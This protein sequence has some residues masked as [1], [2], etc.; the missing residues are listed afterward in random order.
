MYTLDTTAPN[1]HHSTASTIRSAAG[2]SRTRANRRV[3]DRVCQASGSRGNNRPSVRSCDVRR[4]RYMGAAK[5][6][7][8]HLMTGAVINVLRMLNWLAEVPKAKT[9]PSPF[10]R[11]YRPPVCAYERGNSPPISKRGTRRGSNQLLIR[12][13]TLFTMQCARVLGR[14]LSRQ[15]SRVERSSDAWFV[16]ISLMTNTSKRRQLMGTSAFK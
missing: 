3:Q 10:V 9:R 12:T 8:Q 14:H 5:T 1:D 11:M 6:H 7:L 4:S 15:K 16:G 2:R 13:P